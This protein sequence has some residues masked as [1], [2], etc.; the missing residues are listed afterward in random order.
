M[1]RD[2]FG[3]L[4]LLALGTVLWLPDVAEACAVCFQTKNDS[5]RI[6]FMATTFFLTTLPLALFGTLVWLVRR[7]IKQL[8]APQQPPA[9]GTP[10]VFDATER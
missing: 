1:K 5:N 7:R 8:D 2:A 10:T 4:A 9:S 3:W 6:A